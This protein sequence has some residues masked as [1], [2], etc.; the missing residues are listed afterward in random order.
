[1]RSLKEESEEAYKRQFSAYIKNGIDADKIEEMYE[2]A[3]AAIRRNPMP[4][5]K[6]TSERYKDTKPKRHNKRKLTLKE[7]RQ[8]IREKKARYLV[9]LQKELAVVGA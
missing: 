8:R 7:R 9:E 6:D 1:M 3:H 5:K 4:P 2:K